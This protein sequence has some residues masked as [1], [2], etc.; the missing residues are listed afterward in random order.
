MEL[1]KNPYF[2]SEPVA[3]K[4]YKLWSLPTGSSVVREGLKIVGREVGP[5]EIVKQSGDTTIG[6]TN[7]DYIFHLDASL[8][9]TAA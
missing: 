4:T 6:K 9:V 7:W 8:D 1:Q 2:V 3:G 5:F